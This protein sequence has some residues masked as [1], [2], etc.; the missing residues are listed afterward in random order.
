MSFYDVPGRD[1]VF[2]EEG[3]FGGFSE[4]EHLLHGFWVLSGG[5]STASLPIFYSFR[6]G[7]QRLVPA[8]CSSSFST[9]VSPAT[10]TQSLLYPFLILRGS[11]LA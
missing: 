9:A 11:P 4:V 8:H 2:T 7:D 10:R 1:S 6:C 3:L 5:S